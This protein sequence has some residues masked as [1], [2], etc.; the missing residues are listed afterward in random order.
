MA[1]PAPLP[2][3][4][5]FD[6]FELDTTSGELRKAGI[7]LRLQPQPFR[8]LLLLL[9]NAGQVVPREEIQRCLWTD[10]TFVDFEHGINF[11]INQIRSALA[12]NAENPRYIETLPKRGYRFVGSVEHPLPSNRM[13]TLPEVASV[14]DA[15]A[16]ETAKR[17]NFGLVAGSVLL[18]MFIAATGY[19][20]YS[21][22]IVRHAAAFENFK[23]TRVTNTGS[24]IAAA[25]SP[26]AKY[27]LIIVEDKGKQSLWLR[28]VSTKSDTQ[29]IPPADTFYESPMFSQDGNYFY[30]LKSVNT[31]QTSYD[32]L[33]SPVLG[34]VPQVVGHH[35]DLSGIT[36][37][38]E[39]QRMAFMRLNDRDMEKLQLVTAN[40]D[41]SDSKILAEGPE[42]T[43]PDAIAWSPDGKQIAS[44][45]TRLSDALSAIQ[46]LEIA[47]GRVQTLARFNDSYMRDL[48][49]LPDGRGL[50]V[51]YQD[52]SGGFPQSQI[53]IISYPGGQFRSVTKDA[54]TYWK[55]TISADGKTLATVQGAYTQTLYL[56]PATG[57]VGDHPNPAP[58]QNRDSMMFGWAT[59]GD[60]YFDG[61]GSLL[62]ISPDGGTK[63]TLLD[64]SGSQFWRPTGCPVGR[65]VV[66]AWADHQHS[67]KI[68]V[69]RTDTD[70]LNPKQLT[71]GTRDILP[72]CSPNGKWVYYLEATGKV[73]R[74]AIDGGESQLVPGTD[75][76]GLFG[77]WISRDGKLLTCIA[78]MDVQG[79]A[80]PRILL[81]NLDA[82]PQP[83]TRMIVPDP[84]MSGWL[85]F[86]PNGEAVVYPV[87]ENGT[88]N[89]WLQPLD[90][91][92]GHQ[93]TNFKSD[94]IRT[95]D[96][97]PDGMT[98][99]VLRSHRQS[100]VILLHDTSDSR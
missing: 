18:L 35:I 20:I 71:N 15:T 22:F 30:V 12:D 64:E 28:N 65:Y 52:K 34:G 58:A 67:K 36:F 53:G 43:A 26:D 5:H 25:I 82:G 29:V 24:A 38:P 88:D 31:I 84:R 80:A 40:T 61:V 57:S 2:A 97:S 60:I 98:L 96:F 79:P 62:R 47:S 10:S 21:L 59:N 91:S 19:G 6:A 70:G 16:V 93:I 69:W 9:E 14:H 13:D 3:R 68:N 76:P 50:L 8:V 7:L 27:L 77:P 63:T 100:D 11:S 45:V 41:G 86:T 49:W 74:V 46:L 89:L 56:L 32:L 78:G 55:F 72:A 81:V 48:V 33:R 85:G 1:S 92:S 73:M 99:G 54:N 75:L 42:S 23:I 66:F 83:P 39:G 94:S 17:R 44:T 37:S 90:G 4:I 87:R 51:N 95:F